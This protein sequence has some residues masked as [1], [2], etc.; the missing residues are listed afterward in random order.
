MY[1]HI[2][3]TAQMPKSLMPCHATR[4]AFVIAVINKKKRWSIHICI[5]NIVPFWLTISPPIIKISQLFYNTS[6]NDHFWKIRVKPLTIFIIIIT[7]IP[8]TNWILDLNKAIPLVYS[9]KERQMWKELGSRNH[10]STPDQLNDKEDT[11][12]SSTTFFFYYKRLQWLTNRSWK[13]VKCLI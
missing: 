2:F 7:M 6:I 5:Q 13:E 4:G 8:T 9:H 10:I 3:L 12:T 11:S 1:F